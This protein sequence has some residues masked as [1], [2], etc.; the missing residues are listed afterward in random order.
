MQFCFGRGPSLKCPLS[1]SIDIRRARSSYSVGRC[2]ARVAQCAGGAPSEPQDVRIP[3][4]PSLAAACLRK[5]LCTMLKS[6]SQGWAPPPPLKFSSW[7]EPYYIWS[8][9]FHK[10]CNP[11]CQCRCMCLKKPMMGATWTLVWV[12]CERIVSIAFSCVNLCFTCTVYHNKIAYVIDCDS[13]LFTTYCKC[14]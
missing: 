4:T 7:I 2:P 9:A 3:E 10:N 5:R 13:V 11:Q 14:A 6:S 1:Q 8:N 12:F